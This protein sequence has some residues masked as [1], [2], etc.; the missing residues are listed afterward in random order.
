MT[1][2]VDILDATG[3]QGMQRANTMTDSPTAP[4]D[5]RATPEPAPSGERVRQTGAEALVRTLKAS[6]VVDFFGV[7][8]GSLAGVLKA[9][10]RDPAVRF[11]GTR[12][13]A[14]GGFMAA[15]TFHATGTVAACLGEQGP[16]SLNLLSGLGTAHNNNL[17]LVAVTASPP[18]TR[19]H[20]FHGMFMEFDGRDLF[21]SMTKWSGQVTDVRRI[22]A[23][24]RWALREALSGCPGPVHV[25][26]PSDVLLGSAE[27]GPAE[28]DAPLAHFVPGGRT[29]GEPAAIEEAARLLDG[30]ER[31]LLIAGG[32]VAV[33]AASAEFRELQ[34]RVLAAATTTQ[35]GLGTV[36]SAAPD[37]IGHGGVIGGPAILRAMR[38]ADVVLAVGCRF[39]S[40]MWDG[41]APGAPGWPAQHL[42]QVD[43]DPTRIG[44]LRPVSVAIAGDAKT[45]L[46]QLLGSLGQREAVSAG[47]SAWVRSLVDDYRGYRSELDALAATRSEVMHPATLARAFGEAVPEDAL[48]VYDGGHT[49]FWSNE[50][51]PAREPRTRFH[52][53]GMAHLGFGL[54]YALAL[55]LRYPDRPVFNVTGDGAFG[56]T[57]Q[58]LDTARR[59]G[60]PAITLIHD[61]ASFGII[62]A[63]QEQQGFELGASLEGTDCVAVA[64]AFGC[65]GE[66]VTE[67]AELRPALRRALDA[68]LPAVIDARVFFEG[69]P[70]LAAFRRMAT[71][72][73]RSEG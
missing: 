71:P 39:S 58:E 6:G 23:V 8:G 2:S 67:P 50:F 45:V 34:R 65:F 59:H 66:R 33:S 37:F 22:P 70:E 3:D 15:A 21:R 35:M 27:F 61:N 46:A 62:R 36:D 51:T 73:P 43:R 60:L 69:Y 31:P 24:I 25:D 63:G 54:P 13:E 72:A 64:Q 9:I 10:A 38:E 47:R 55:Q 48:V 14:S 16:G 29:P 41:D 1:L 11:V 12:H 32:G 42:I 7:P 40:W 5:A 56:F 18:T 44:R 4:P 52:D 30:A 53:P 26:V 17:A 57:L 19:T 49:T 28:L 68:G 20:P